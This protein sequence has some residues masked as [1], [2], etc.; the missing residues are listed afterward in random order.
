M[1]R[2]TATLVPIMRI[3]R[4]SKRPLHRQIYDAYRSTI[5]R[6]ELRPGQQVPASRL[7]ATELKIS[8]IPV[9]GAYAQLLAE[10]YL[11]ARIGAGTFVSRS[12]PE[13][14]THCET[15][16][17]SPQK[18]RSG[19]RRVSRR[20]AGLPGLAADAWWQRPSAFSIS[21][22]ALDHFPMRLWSDLVRRHARQQRVSSLLYGDPMGREDFR[23]AI[24]DYLRS[25]RAV[26]CDPEQIMIVSGSQQALQI[27]AHALLGAG[28]S[29][30]MEEPGYRLARAVFALAGCRLI[31]VPVDEEGLIVSQ[32]LKR[33]R[34]ARLAY[35]T[36]SHQYPLGATMSAAR[37]IQLLEWAQ[38]CDA[39][40]VEDDYDSEYRYESP[41]IASLQGLDVD[42]RVI[43][44]GTFSKVL[45][46][47]LRVGYIVI[48]KD[49]MQQFLEVRVAMDI[50]PP[51]LAQSVLTEFITAGHFARHIRRMR[52]L[53]GERRSALAQNIRDIFAGELTVHG[54]DSGMHLAA[55]LPVGVRDQA[56]AQRGAQ[57][58]L[59]LWPLSP[60]YLGKPTQQ[61]LILGFGNVDVSEMPAAVERLKKTVYAG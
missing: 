43:Y 15:S 24:A 31:A 34:N 40:L 53:Y 14:L 29:V 48:P 12:L 35:V 49:L 41:P 11:E 19:S 10:G 52:L 26:R 3:D 37:R 57:R 1:K 51:D 5:L 25:A 7:L 47:S 59:S 45:F 42:A 6:G 54:G 33:A 36:P 28:D 22:P 23:A 30:W 55:T 27:I 61:G 60:S 44:V 21:Y 46:P 13:Q 2:V 17:R 4:Q 32:G 58:R 56:V 16:G 8:R 39:W 50:G 20:G 18:L 38:T 9:L